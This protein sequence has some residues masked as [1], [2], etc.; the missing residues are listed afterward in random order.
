MIKD[1]RGSIQKEL[2]DEGK[3]PFKKYSSFFWGT[4]SFFGFLRFEVIIVFFSWLPGAAG[5]FLRRLF[6]P[7][8]FKRVGKGVVFGRNITLRHPHKISLGDNTFIDDNVVLDAKGEKNEGLRIGKNVYLG[9]NTI[10]SCKEGSIFLDDYCNLSANCSLLSETEIKM[11]KYC[12]LAGQ[13]YLVA[14]GNHTYDD[15]SIPIMFQPSFTKG[16]IRIDE[17]VWLGAGVIVLD[18]VTIGKGT[19]VGAGSVV[20]ESLG[21][22]SIAVGTPAKKIKD[23]R[24]KGGVK[25]V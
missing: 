14:G 19:V 7:S 4:K 15:I 22:Y 17:D 13:C 24:D 5:F 8:L 12:F 10:L 3:S 11:G 2:I 20:T 1:F 21:E 6:Y 18:G 16:G 9:R 25:K 23:R